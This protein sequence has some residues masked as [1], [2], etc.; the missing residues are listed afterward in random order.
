MSNDMLAEEVYSNIATPVAYEGAA[1]SY[2]SGLSGLL[3][4]SPDSLAAREIMYLQ[5]RTAHAIRNNGY[6]KA[7]KEKYITALGTIS[8][9]WKTPEGEEHSEMQ[10]L[11]NE[12][13]E[14]PNYDSYGSFANTQVLCNSSLFETGATFI[15]YMYQRRRNNNKIPL[16]L[17]FIP[18]QLHDITYNGTTSAENIF[19]G[20]KFRNETPAEYYFRKGTWEKEF[21]KV[22]NPHKPIVVPAGDLLHV[23]FK[24]SPG[25][26]IGVP[27][28]ASV[29]CTLYEL[30][31]LT[32]ATVAKQKAAQAIAWIVEG[33]NATNPVPLGTAVQV[34]DEDPAKQKI[35]FK[36]TGGSVQYLNKGERIN[37][38]QSTDIGPNLQVLIKSELY[39]VA[40]VADIAY[41]MLTGD[42]SGLD[43]SSLRGIALELR[44]RIEFIHNV[45]TVPI[46]LAPL[47][48]KFKELSTL[49]APG[50]ANAVPTYQLPRWYGVDGLKD[51]QEDVLE[52][53][54]GIGTIKRALEERHLTVEEV[55]A[56]RELLKTLGL[57]HLLTGGS[58]GMN[59]PNNFNSNSNSTG[60]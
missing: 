36:N 39:K 41:Y 32:D 6:A 30:D 7:A 26:W 12:F 51:A 40:A 54:N 60:N 11:W 48:G 57:E 13:A 8:I 33:T 59:Q 17:K 1:T 19:Y 37:F 18:T 44:K 53:Q 50:V 9:Q 52:I 29:L 38:F 31:E 21:L 25:Q 16:K 4:G 3:T 45:Y 22:A 49:Y 46:F 35:I 5:M 55:I 15:Q 14:N 2:K 58:Q 47:A 20:I 43:F 23:F 56:D 34:R 27:K 10:E 24:D 28:L 42:T